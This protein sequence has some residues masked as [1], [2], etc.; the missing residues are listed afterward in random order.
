MFADLSVD[1]TALS[2]RV[3]YERPCRYVPINEIKEQRER[4]GME[5]NGREWK[6]MEGNGR[7]WKGQDGKGRERKGDEEHG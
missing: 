2:Q 3:F 6:G 5:G 1:D 7:E 4:K